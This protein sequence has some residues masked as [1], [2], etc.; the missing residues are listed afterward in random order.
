MNFN[1]K[2]KDIKNYEAGKPIELVVREFGIEPK[3]IIKLAS[4][5]NP[6]GCS[7]KVQD[8]VSKI[9]SKM[10][11]YPDDSMIALKSALS[12]RFDVGVS[13][14]IIGS[15]SD[16]V[17]EFLIHAKANS[18]SKILMNSITFAMYEIYAKHVGAEILRTSSQEHDLDEFYKIYKEEKPSIIFLCTPN[19]PT[20][21]A[22]EATKLFEFL[23]KIDS[24]TLV[25]VDGAYMEYA[26]VKDS[27]KEVKPK[28]LVE[29][30]DNVIYLG[31]F[32][33]A[34]GLGGMRVGY[35]VADAKI[36]KELYK[37]R[38]PFNIT[39][40]SLEAATIALGDEEFVNK[41]VVNNFNEMK[42]YEEFAKE[43]KIDII[44][45]YTN[46][47]TLCLNPNQISSVIADLLLKKGMIVRDL[48]S[49]GMNAIRVTVGTQEQNSRFFELASEIL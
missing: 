31:T 46:F 3:D 19:N 36:I 22:I 43:Q 41:S 35:G 38:P 15:G 7:K 29:E 4:N 5:E 45:S 9:I 17:I 42:R 23:K 39:T 18:E 12:K 11:L 27:S 26:L 34:Y 21:D 1:S 40:L 13:N 14:V 44:N 16:Q 6:N 48:S 30:F 49:Y 8:G 25:V 32:S 33:K 20:G 47:V 37:L 2:M 24:D 10:A 28:D